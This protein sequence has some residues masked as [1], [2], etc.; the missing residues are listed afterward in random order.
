MCVCVCVC[1]YI[2]IYIYRDPPFLTKQ[3]ACSFRPNGVRVPLQSKMFNQFFLC[4]I[5]ITVAKCA[6]WAPLSL[7]R[8]L[9]LSRSLSVC[10]CV[11]VCVRAC[12]CVCV[13]ARVCVSYQL[14]G[15]LVSGWGN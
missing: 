15:W 9:S 1:I 10:V 3:E 8:A 11:C 7:A 2:Y 13:R 14:L 4:I 5:C 12:V 6:G